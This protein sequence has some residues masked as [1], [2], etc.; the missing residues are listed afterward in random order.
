MN[1]CGSVSGVTS[2]VPKLFRC[3]DHLET[4]GEAQNIDFYRDSRT[5]SANDA[6]HTLGTTGLHEGFRV[7]DNPM[8]GLLTR[9][10]YKLN[11]EQI[12]SKN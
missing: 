8:L 4:F 12:F 2:V 11:E 6:E 9:V 5:T 7:E 10:G 1:L 3:A